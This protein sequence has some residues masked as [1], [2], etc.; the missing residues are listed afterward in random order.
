MAPPQTARQV[1]EAVP[2]RLVRFG[3]VGAIS[4]PSHYGMLILL[5]E[6]GGADPVLSTIAGSAVGL[7]VN[8]SLN[9]R[10]TFRSKKRN[11]DAGP[12]FLTVAMATGI[13]NAA[14]VYLGTGP[15]GIHYLPVQILTTLIVFLA[16][17]AAHSVWTFS[18][19]K[20]P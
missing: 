8:Y 17:F 1:I 11:R 18:E 15:L 3:L 4:L 6:I 14:L 9:R 2:R 19:S 12:I 13:L 5:V 7:V 16:N 20:A 10:F